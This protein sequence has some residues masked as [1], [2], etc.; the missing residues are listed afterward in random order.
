MIA[1]RAAT[2][3]AF[4]LALSSTGLGCGGG[5]SR[6]DGGD[7][8]LDVAGD[9]SR[10]GTD[11]GSG[12]AAI[13]VDTPSG[14]MATESLDGVCDILEAVAAAASGRSVDECA[15]PNGVTRI[16]L[17]GGRTY[18]VRKTLRLPAAVEIGLADGAT[19]SARSPQHPGSSSTLATRRPP[20]WFRSRRASRTSGCAT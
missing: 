3:M 8:Q 18:P 1:R 10:E 14:L 5:G 12:G 20:V 16:V 2:C 7:A 19:G 6:P 17:Q 4:G 15:N 11:G 13:V 9:G